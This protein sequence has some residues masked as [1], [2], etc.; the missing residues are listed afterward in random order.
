M[1]LVNE[2]FH[3]MVKVESL[4]FSRDIEKSVSITGAGGGPVTD[5]AVI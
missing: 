1:A 5:T 4:S 2:R 3:E